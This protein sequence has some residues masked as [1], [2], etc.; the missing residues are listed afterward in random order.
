[1]KKYACINVT[2]HALVRWLERQHGADLRAYREAIAQTVKDAVNVGASKVTIDGMTYVLEKN[3]VVTV[4]PGRYHAGSG[5]VKRR[6][7]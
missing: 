5:D 3:N 4:V 1:M 6:H 7:Y 2:D